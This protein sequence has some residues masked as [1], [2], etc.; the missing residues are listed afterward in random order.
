[1]SVC[2]ITPEEGTGSLPKH[3]EVIAYSMPTIAEM[4]GTTVDRVL[5]LDAWSVISRYQY[6]RHSELSDPCIK[7]TGVPGAPF[8]RDSRTHERPNQYPGEGIS[9]YQ[10]RGGDIKYVVIYFFVGNSGYHRAF[11]EKGNLFRLKRHA[12][13]QNKKRAID[14]LCPILCEEVATNVIRNTV[15]L[16]ENRSQYKKYAKHLK[17]GVLFTGPPGN[18]KTLMCQ[19]IQGK[20]DMFGLS[21]KIVKIGEIEKH[22][23][24]GKDVQ[25]IFDSSD[26]I[27]V[28]DIELTH[29]DRSQGKGSLACAILSALDGLD[30]SR[31]M[32]KIFTTNEDVKSIDKAFSRPGRIDCIFNFDPPDSA[33]RYR[34]VTE[35]WHEE[36]VSYLMNKKVNECQRGIDYIVEFSEGFSF[37]ELDSIQSLMICNKICLDE[38]D[39]GWDLMSALDEYKVLRESAKNGHR[40]ITVGF[41]TEAAG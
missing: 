34:L 17:K 19:Y 32:L 18:G 39:N 37:A 27:F 4:L 8:L 38:E 6:H 41:A 7:S 9:C 5:A 30:K 22:F 13:R 1:M 35:W 36:I 26:V 23:S 12:L 15:T 25:E 21:S 2:C 28:D 40:K 16:M 11:V 29:L 20:A 33:L 14:T 3:L 10:I 24:D 31:S